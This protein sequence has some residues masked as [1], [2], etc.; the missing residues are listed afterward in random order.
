MR[1]LIVLLALLSGMSPTAW[2]KAAFQGKGEM[3]DKAEAIAII[4]LS[5][6]QTTNTQGTAFAYRQKANARAETVLKGK[7]PEKFPLYGAETFICAQ[8]PLS[9]GRYLAFLKRDGDLWTGANW[10]SSLRPI[11][12]KQVEWF[13][14][15]TD[16]FEKKSVPLAEVL[17][18]IRD[19]LGSKT[20]H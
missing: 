17:K 2:A 6:V 15:D 12:D 4:T 10:Q 11:Q 8:C 20:V 3:I 18:E 19:R 16:I 5:E 9:S 14:S 1:T 7:L 13:V